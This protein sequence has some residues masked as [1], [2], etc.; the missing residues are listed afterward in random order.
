MYDAQLCNCSFALFPPT[1]LSSP[2]QNTCIQI[3]MDTVQERKPKRPHYIPRPPGK[4]FKY[5][6]FQCPFTC[7]EKSHLFNH[8]KYNLCKNSISL[9]SQKNGQ[10]ARQFK[11]PAKGVPSKP[12]DC[13]SPVAALRENASEKR[14]QEL[15]ENEEGDEEKVKTRSVGETERADAGRDVGEKDGQSVSESNTV[16]QQESKESLP[17]PSAFSPV[18]PKGDG[19]ESFKSP[20]DSHANVPSFKH[21]GFPWATIPTSLSFKPLPPPPVMP[22]YSPFLLPDATLYPPYYLSGSPHPGEANPPSFRPEFLDP[23][24]PVVPQPISPPQ[25]SLFPPY[26]YRYC[27]PLQPGPPLHYT[28]YRPH[29]LS[30]PLTEPRYIPFDLYGSTYRPKE[31][32]E[33]YMHSH[34]TQD[35]VRTPAEQNNPAAAEGEDKDTR[36]S[37][38]A[39]CS[40][41]GSPDRPSH[42]QVI[43]RDAEA[44]RCSDDVVGSQC[45][46]PVVTRDLQQEESAKSLL[47][48]RAQRVDGG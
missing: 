9:M 19:T 37:P 6:C 33:L 34:P 42:A 3:K 36:L 17:R 32:D 22:Q 15:V 41:L 12:K 44:Q 18:T 28:L 4:P 46:A 40:A 43:Q 26:P 13:P 2:L 31:N 27:H 7:N 23:Q 11:A 38:R 47:L 25:T 29:D 1:S 24:R 35:V 39:G 48:L 14:G 16:T 5:Q 8:M 10:A 21:P 45:T 30:M 20:E